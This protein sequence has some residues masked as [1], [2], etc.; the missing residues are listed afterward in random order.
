MK[1]VLRCAFSEWGPGL[2]DNNV[3]GWVTVVVYLVA[4]LGS[5]R[6]LAALDRAD[7]DTPRERLFWGISAAVMLFLALNKQLDLQS[8]LTAVARCHAR[9]SGWYDSR[10]AVQEL[11]I[12]G[13]AAAGVVGLGLMALLMRS[14]LGRVWLAL[15]GL[16]FVCAFV[17][18][19]AASFHHM[20]A[21]IGTWVLGMQMNWLLELPGPALVALVAMRRRRAVLA[22]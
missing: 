16:G 11:F 17:L 2:G 1:T 3:M 4:A 18:M 5:F 10:L 7:P 8:L 22:G 19:R 9:L 6:L 15:L 14:I 12:L 13:V 21:L 20:D